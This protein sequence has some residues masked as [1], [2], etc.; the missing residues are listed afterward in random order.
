VSAPLPRLLG[1]RGA[2][3]HAPENTL[4]SLQAAARLGAE[5]VEFDVQR[6]RDGVL[7]LLHDDT[8]E[9]TT[10][11]RGLATARTWTELSA[12]DAGARFGAAFA[13]TRLPTLEQAIACCEALGLGANVEIKCASGNDEALGREIAECVARRWPAR[14]PPPL[15]SSFSDAALHAARAAQPELRRGLCVESLPAD[16]WTRL[17][18]TGAV[19]LHPDQSRLTRP[20]AASV[21]AR[22]I[23]VLAW[24]VNTAPRAAVLKSWGIDGFFTDRVEILRRAT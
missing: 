4:P 19:S 15:L 17:R 6:S 5:W 14:L 2:L 23:P 3:L 9:R 10:D 21:K 1:H 16:W 13:G 20:L 11:G 22:Q 18:A 24:T 12:L 7:F 8:L